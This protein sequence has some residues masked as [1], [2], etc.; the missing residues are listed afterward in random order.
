MINF[1]MPWPSSKHDFCFFGEI[2]AKTS[3][4]KIILFRRAGL[5]T[6][7]VGIESLSTTMLSRMKKGT[8]VM[9]NLAIMKHCS[10][11]G[12]DL[13]GNIITEFPATSR[14]EIEEILVNLDYAL[15]YHPLEAAS[16]F[17]GYGAPI[18]RS[19]P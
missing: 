9:D 8:T 6:V 11:N 16:F 17:L 12:I 14:G 10:A 3:L 18:Y 2:R 19:A 1:S 7:Q 4:E 5:R 13:L 15:P